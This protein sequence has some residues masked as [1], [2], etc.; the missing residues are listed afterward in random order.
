MLEGLGIDYLEVLVHGIA[1]DDIVRRH[2]T[3]SMCR[4]ASADLY[5]VLQIAGTWR[6]SPR[7]GILRDS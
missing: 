4:N 6:N 5:G 7:R 2:D 3:F 1:D